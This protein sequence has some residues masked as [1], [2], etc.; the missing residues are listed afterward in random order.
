MNK[1]QEQTYIEQTLQGNHA[2]YA[3]LVNA[4]KDHVFT[5]LLRIVLQRETAEELAQDVF[6]KAYQHLPSF[7]RQAK[8]STWLYRIAYNTAISHVRKRKHPV[9]ELEEKILRTD[10]EGNEYAKKEQLLNALT[11]AVAQLPPEEAALITLFYM[12][13][14]PMNDICTIT[15]LSLSNVKTK[16]HRIRTKL[17]NQLEGALSDE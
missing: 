8:L 3:A 6:L 9:C 11:G 14:K 5:L 16:I 1:V 4:H 13:D 15:G 10:D 2:A 12:E 17:R 7:N